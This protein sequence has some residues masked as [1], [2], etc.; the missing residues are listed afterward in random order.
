LFGETIVLLRGLLSISNQGAVVVIEMLFFFPF[1]VVVICFKYKLTFL[2]C[3]FDDKENL[4]NGP[5]MCVKSPLKAILMAMGTICHIYSSL[6]SL[7]Y[8]SWCEWQAS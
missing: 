4:V 8:L 7:E 5:C 1:L 6:W 2:S 3:N